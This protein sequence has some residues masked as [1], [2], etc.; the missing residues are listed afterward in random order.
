MTT[1]ANDREHAPTDESEGSRPGEGMRRT[2]VGGGVSIGRIT[3]GAIAV[4]DGATATD[5]SEHV[6][7][8]E[9]SAG[10]SVTSPPV[11]PPSSGVSIGSVDGGALSVGPGA[12]ALDNSRHWISVPRDLDASLRTLR[13]E[14]LRIDRTQGDGID[15]LDGQLAA[16]E[17]DIA[18]QGRTTP[19]RLR[20]LR[21]LLIGGGTAVSGVASALAVVDS[22]AQLLP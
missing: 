3:G 7:S 17:G 1:D 11:A 18:G 15:E 16:I 20:R 21:S 9:D 13:A 5:Q 2:G 4:G 6:G 19:D 22:I 10:P 12:N 14:L 8:R